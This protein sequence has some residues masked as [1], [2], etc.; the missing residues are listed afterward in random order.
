MHWSPSP[1]ALFAGG[2]G[3]GEAGSTNLIINRVRA[4]GQKYNFLGLM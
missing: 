3:R 1:P 2:E 4:T